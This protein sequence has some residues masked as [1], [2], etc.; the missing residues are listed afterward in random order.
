MT[1][2]DHVALSKNREGMVLFLPHENKLIQLSLVI[3]M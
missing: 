1:E 2:Q 3:N